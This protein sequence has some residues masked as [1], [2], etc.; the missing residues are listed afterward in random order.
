M[1]VQS[2]QHDAAA[3]LAAAN[4]Q[5]VSHGGRALVPPQGCV[6]LESLPGGRVVLVN[7]PEHAAA[8]GQDW[9]AQ[10]VGR[11]G[12]ELL[13]ADV[14]RGAVVG[15][16]ALLTAL[17]QMYKDLDISGMALTVTDMRCVRRVGDHKET[18]Y[19]MCSAC[20]RDHKK[21]N[22]RVCSSSAC[23]CVPGSVPAEGLPGAGGMR[24]EEPC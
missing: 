15:H 9:F 18:N 11:E 7:Q 20:V 6:N 4:I 8:E 16:P 23:V 21:T 19:C 3:H 10:D 24:G 12:F 14:K 1:D 17:Q 22:D 2:R 13:L 5:T